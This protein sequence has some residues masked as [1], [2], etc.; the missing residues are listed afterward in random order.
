MIL[1]A[2]TVSLVLGENG[3]I[4]RAQDATNKT[5]EATKNEQ[6]ALADL[7][8]H[9][10]EALGE[11][12]PAKPGQISNTNSQYTDSEGKTVIIP[13]GFGVSEET[14]EQKV[15]DGLVIKD[16]SGNEF[17]WI[18][19]TIDGANGTVKYEKWCTTG[20]AYNNSGISN[21]TLPSGVSSEEEQ[22]TKYGG[23]YIAKYEAGIPDSLSTAQTTANATTRNVSGVPI[24]KQNA[25]PW[26]YINYTNAKA[27]AESMY[28]SGSVQSGLLTG[29]MWDTVMKWLQNAG[30]SVTDSTAW[31]NYNNAPVTNITEYSTNYER[32]LTA[33]SVTKG[34]STSWLLKT[35]HSKYTEANNIYDLAGNMYEWTNEIF[36]SG[37]VYRGRQLQ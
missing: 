29:T 27:N 32:W 3:I 30:Y 24:S 36:S 20:I 10:G 25:V 35:G 1:A 16:S 7:D 17:I 31:G 2:A 37:R 6:N 11:T 13:G 8:A 22:I 33:S 19:C 26:N 23:F 9:I 5:N 28:S 15:S 18:P 34:T 14:S 4:A 21:D 12:P